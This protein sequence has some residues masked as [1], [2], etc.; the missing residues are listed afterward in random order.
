[1][2][3]GVGGVLVITGEGTIEGEVKKLGKGCILKKKLGGQAENALAFRIESE[4]DL[5]QRGP[6]EGQ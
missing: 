5:N 4:N 3:R 1:V 6:L 2:Q